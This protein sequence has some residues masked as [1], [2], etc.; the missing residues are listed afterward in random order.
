[1]RKILES[2][3]MM[4]GSSLSHVPCPKSYSYIVHRVGDIGALFKFYLWS[5]QK[6]ETV[7]C[8]IGESTRPITTE[9]F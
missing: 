9:K 6:L 4:G 1:M 7:F 3:L 8:V 5:V 2:G